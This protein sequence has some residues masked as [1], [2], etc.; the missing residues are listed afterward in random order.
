VA[1]AATP[2]P[3]PA[4]AGLAD[5]GAD[6][7]RAA[8]SSIAP[9]RRSSSRS[10]RPRRCAP[11]ARVAEDFGECA[12]GIALTLGDKADLTISAKVKTRTVYKPSRKGVTAGKPTLKF[13]VAK[14][15]RKTLKKGAMLTRTA[16]I[17]IKEAARG[18]YGR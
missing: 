3:T 9:P 16:K 15:S 5:A 11:R 7:G 4:A 2:T 18:P 8:V 13:T 1:A 17:K 6:G 12:F 14:S 10:R